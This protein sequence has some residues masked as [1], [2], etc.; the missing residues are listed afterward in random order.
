MTVP[1]YSPLWAW[2]RAREAIRLK[3]EAGAPPPWIE[4]PILATYRFCN[5][6]REDDLVTRWVRSHVRDPYH[7]HPMLSV[8]AV[9][10]TGRIHLRN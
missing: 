10:S 1:D 9:R 5:V 3:K 7:D 6:R 2:I 4:D 8:Y